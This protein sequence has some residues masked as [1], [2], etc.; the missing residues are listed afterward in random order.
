MASQSTPAADAKALVE[1]KIQEGLYKVKALGHLCQE[2]DGE[3][4]VLRT[5]CYA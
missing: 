4:E 3:I 2:T 5:Q 1:A